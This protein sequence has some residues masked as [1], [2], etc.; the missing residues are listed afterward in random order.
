MEPK[1]LKVL[2]LPLP[3]LF[4]P[5]C[6]DIV[7]AL[8][9]RHDLRIYE[10]DR[11][12]AAQFPDVDVVID[13]G[14]HIGTHEMM[15]AAVGARL[16]QILSVGYEHVDIAHLKSRGM[17]VANV[18][19][20]TS[21]LSLAQTALLFI[22]MLAHRIR[23]CER[24]F[25]SGRWLEP[26]GHELEGMTLGIVGLGH[27]GRRLA[28]LGTALGMRVIA[29]NRSPIDSA[30]IKSLGL[31]R[32]FPW[33]QLDSLIAQ[34]DFI[35]LHLTL[36][37][38]T[39]E[40]MNARRIGLMKQTACLINIARGG[41][42]DESALYEALLSNK[43]GGAGLDVFDPE[44]PDPKHPVFSLTNV[45]ATPHIAGFTDGSSR[46]RA[47]FVAENVERIA[48]GLEPLHQVS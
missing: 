11:S 47:K 41:L 29:A 28:H 16:W 10:P 31:E 7:S 38:Q 44:P 35:S 5:W 20:Q 42:V 19:G 24:Y 18:P 45:V 26:M 22:L 40:I 6:E 23:E 30:T 9:E 8:G 4:K 3:G 15:D 39:R 2:L 37:D 32:I 21:A 1:R 36:S 13:H 33:D 46:K 25:H 12:V 48:Q 34:S 14:G 17:T 43:I 27:S